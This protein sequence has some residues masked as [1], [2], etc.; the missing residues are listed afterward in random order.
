[1]SPSLALP[2]ILRIGSEF[3]FST[4]MPRHEDSTV[5]SILFVLNASVWTAD[6][7][8]VELD[9]RICGPVALWLVLQ[10]LSVAQPLEDILAQMPQR[11][12][13]SSFAELAMFAQSRGLDSRAVE[14]RV[15]PEFDEHEFPAIIPVSGSRQRRH[16]IAL[17][18][19][20]AGSL[21]VQ[22]FPNGAKWVTEARLRQEF[23]WDGRALHFARH[24]K[25]LDR[26]TTGAVNL[27]GNVLLGFALLAA[28]FCGMA[29]ARKRWTKSGA[30]APTGRSGYTLIDLVVVMSILGLLM[31]LLMPAAERSREAAR[32]LQCLNQQRELGLAIAGFS[33]AHS[34]LPNLGAVPEVNG[35]FGINVASGV[36]IHTLLLP[37][38]DQVAVYQQVQYASGD[39]TFGQQGV[40]SALNSELLRKRIAVFECPSDS[41]PAG[42]CSYVLSGGTSPG[43]HTNTDL[44]A[45][46]AA[47]SGYVGRLLNDEAALA[48][49]LSQTV[50]LSERL[51]GDRNPGRYTPARDHAYLSTFDGFSAATAAQSCLLVPDPPASHFSHIGTC[52]LAS[53]YGYTWYNHILTPNSRTPDCSDSHAATTGCHTARSW[54]FG[55]VN[56]MSGDGA[57][58]FISE[59]ID[60]NVWRALGTSRGSETIAVEGLK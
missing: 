49:G 3:R 39:I 35:P 29:L 10:D 16:F 7:S 47:M 22:D 4:I 37:F 21:K 17:L 30:T 43:L 34:R 1:M 23:G 52:W 26:L 11:G 33:S 14:W 20:K 28:T 56:A 60:L 13:D 5:F 50:I 24:G 42:G 18:A 31:A 19:S 41:V 32:R 15:V 59:N 8:A 51:V 48:D 40:S 46:D 27:R 54:H 2:D 36:S 58:R 6:P 12:A 9:L 53:G 57:A 55:G 45:P 44:V 38:L 25:D